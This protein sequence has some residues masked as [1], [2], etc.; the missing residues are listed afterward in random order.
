MPRR[1][2]AMSRQRRVFGNADVFVGRDGGSFRF[3]ASVSEEPARKSAGETA[4]NGG[5][6]WSGS[7]YWRAR[8]IT[9]SARSGFLEIGLRLVNLRLNNRRRRS[10][11]RLATI[12]GERF[13]REKDRLFRDAAGRRGSGRLRRAMVEAALRGTARFE[14]ARLAAAIFLATLVTA[15]ILVATRFVA[16]RFPTLR[17]SIFGRR[18]VAT[19]YVRALPLALRSPA[20]MPSTPTPP[21]PAAATVT[22]AITTAAIAATVTTAAIALAAAVGT[23]GR[24]RRVILRGVVVGRKILGSGSVRFRLTLFV[25]V[26]DI[27]V[28][29]I[30]NFGDVSIGDFAFC[31]GLFDDSGMLF[32]GEGIV[33]QRFVIG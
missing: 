11:L 19:A 22:A 29:F 33:V 31:N 23:T 24:S 26:M 1:I 28:A 20:A 14:P 18:K 15:T 9:G 4:W 8:K 10:N 2:R 27:V 25:G 3:R 17:R 5:T 21:S 12:F 16:A 30:V 13:A 6:G 32:V 7:R